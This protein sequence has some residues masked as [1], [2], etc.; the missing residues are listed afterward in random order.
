MEM[1]KARAKASGMPMRRGRVNSERANALAVGSCRKL[2]HIERADRMMK[3]E[4]I[5]LSFHRSTEKTL[6]MMTW[7]AGPDTSFVTTAGT[8]VLRKSQRK[9]SMAKTPRRP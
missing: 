2:I 9:L 5:R 3:K 1:E 4:D 8:K 6:R 7:W